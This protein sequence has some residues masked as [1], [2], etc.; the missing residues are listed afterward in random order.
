VSTAWIAIILEG[1]EIGFLLPLLAGHLLADFPL[2]PDSWVAQRQ[3]RGWRAP[4]LYLNGALAALL[5]WLFVARWGAWWIL[6]L[7]GATHILIDGVKAR[8]GDS[9]RV[10]L[11]DQAAHL[12]VLLGVA[13]FLTRDAG[14]PAAPDRRAGWALACGAL[15]VWWV[16]GVF[17]GKATRRWHEQLPD[18][19]KRT[20]PDAGLWIGRLERAL[21]FVFVL[22][23]QFAAIGFLITAKSVLRIGEVARGGD[24]REAE[25]ILIGT[26]MSFLLAILAGLAT[27]LVMGLPPTG[28]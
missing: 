22:L 13:W 14:V 11:L 4:A 9:A 19:G 27:R 5:G 8:G 28:P 7:I 23:G 25:Y 12:A 3:E 15:L 10:F 26:M 21:T 17:V 16:A 2:Q 1:R 18:D 20:L 6:P 24:R